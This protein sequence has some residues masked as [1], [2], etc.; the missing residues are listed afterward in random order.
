MRVPLENGEV[1]ILTSLR[2]LVYQQRTSESF[3][4][5][6]KSPYK[7]IGAFYLLN[8]AQTPKTQRQGEDLSCFYSWGSPEYGHC[9]DGTGCGDD[10]GW[11]TG[12]GYGW[13]Y[14]SYSQNGWGDGFTK[15]YDSSREY[16]CVGF[17]L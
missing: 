3:R 10:L 12:W 4:L 11:G 13:I 17:K 7:P 14:G 9:G 5:V 15:G 16:G 8:H 6:Y 2:D 1:N